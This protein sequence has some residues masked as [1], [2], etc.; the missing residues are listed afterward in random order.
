MRA[1][2]ECEPTIA[3]AQIRDR[4]RNIYLLLVGSLQL[5][6]I[7]MCLMEDSNMY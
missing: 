1:F 5:C 7:S 4:D 3:L 6:R 2:V